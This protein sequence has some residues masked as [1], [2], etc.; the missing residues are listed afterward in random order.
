MH[1]QA[2]RCQHAQP[3]TPEYIHPHRCRVLKYTRRRR[4]S[5]LPRVRAVAAHNGTP[6]RRRTRP[7]PS[8]ARST[9]GRHSGTDKQQQRH[10]HP[11]RAARTARV[12][13][14]RCLG[15][16]CGR[17]LG[18]LGGSSSRSGGGSRILLR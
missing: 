3:K 10:L 13:R 9:G 16:S 7:A 11:H 18:R 17:V 12:F 5:V 4:Q 6:D 15:G 8:S 1:G 2:A 14:S